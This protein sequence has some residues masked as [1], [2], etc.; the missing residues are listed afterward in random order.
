VAAIVATSAADLI[1]LD[2]VIP[3]LVEQGLFF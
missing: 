3:L 2:M 1:R